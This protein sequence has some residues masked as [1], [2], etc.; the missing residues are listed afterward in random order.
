M[1]AGFWWMTI[2]ELVPSFSLFRWACRG[3]GGRV[4]GAGQQA[5]LDSCRQD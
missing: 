3:Q 2:V 4:G 5:C 1:G